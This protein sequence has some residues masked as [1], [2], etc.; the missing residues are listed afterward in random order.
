M[1]Q[2]IL[3]ELTNE[4]LKEEAKKMKKTSIFDALVFGLLIGI[5]IYSSVKNGIG[6]LTFLPLLYIPVATKNKTKIKELEEALKE[7][8]VQ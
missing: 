6:L 2:K 1:K 4:E 3:A 8:N 5:A 7:R